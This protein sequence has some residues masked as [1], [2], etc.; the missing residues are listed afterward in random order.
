V[1]TPA[2]AGSVFEMDVSVHRIDVL[3]FSF[4]GRFVFTVVMQQLVP[5]K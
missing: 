3:I 1:L 2:A 5:W 4:L